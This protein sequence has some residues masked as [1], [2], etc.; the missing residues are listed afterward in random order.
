MVQLFILLVALVV[1]YQIKNLYVTQRVLNKILFLIVVVILLVMGYQFGSSASDLWLQLLQVLKNVIVFGG[2]IFVCNIVVTMVIF[3]QTN[4][5]LRHPEHAQI[6]ANYI[7]FAYESGKYLLMIAI[8]II[9]GAVL[10]LPLTHLEMIVNWLLIVLLFIIGHQVR[11]SGVSLV[12]VILNKTGFKL[13]VVIV[14]SSLV[15]GV[16]A[17]M[18]LGMPILN[19]VILSSGFGWYTLSS[20]LIGQLV[21]QDY[22]T[23]AFFIDFSR[24]LIAI[25]LLPSLGRFIPLSMVGYCGATAMDFSLPII[26]QNLDHKCVI[27]AISSGMLLSC[28]VPLLIPLVIKFI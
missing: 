6:K 23:T 25:I 20:I 21:N 14:L 28:A 17:A 16:L 13:A 5:R 7:Q 11:M 22:G 9:L 19:G 27:I 4:K 10:K 18:I 1:G 26:K 8:G 2:L 15:A 3:R 24:E 12:E